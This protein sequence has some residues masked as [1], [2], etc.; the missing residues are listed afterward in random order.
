MKNTI[1][2]KFENVT[3]EWE[4]NKDT[5]SQKWAD[6]VFE[7]LQMSIPDRLHYSNFYKNNKEEYYLRMT[8][9]MEMLKENISDMPSIVDL[10]STTLPYLNELHNWFAKNKSSHELLA[11]MHH[12]LHSLEGTLIY[13]GY[14]FSP[15]L[16]ASWANTPRI[17]FTPDEY[18]NFVDADIFG[19]IVLT[20]CHIGKDPMAIYRSKDRLSDD[21]F[22]P[23]THYSADFTMHFGNT[24]KYPHNKQFWEWFDSNYQWF[25]DRTGWE[26]RDTRI[27]TGRYVVAKLITEINK[28]QILELINPKSTI[29]EII[30]E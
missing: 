29:L 28:E 13:S 12:Y 4:I 23:W 9:A 21:V 3:L 1:K 26:R 18:N 16:Q 15:T 11:E 17:Q 25:Q 19:T 10:D 14:E 27:V 7:S 30:I 5:A 6:A 24:I 8:K 22:V 2:I 20:Y